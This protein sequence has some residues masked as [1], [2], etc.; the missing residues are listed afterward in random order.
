MREN[1]PLE[2]IEFGMPWTRYKQKAEILFV[3]RPPIFLKFESCFL[4]LLRQDDNKAI[5]RNL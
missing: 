5:R 2:N 3:T 4:F 1:S